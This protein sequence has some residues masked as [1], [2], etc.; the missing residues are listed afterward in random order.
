[1]STRRAWIPPRSN[2]TASSRSKPELSR[3]AAIK[4][5]VNVMVELTRL[6]AAGVPAAFT[7]GPRPDAK[8]STKTIANLG[9][10][11]LSLPDRSY[12][13]NTDAKSVE[14]RGRF[15]AHMANMFQLAG[16]TADAAAAKAKLVARFRNAAGAGFDRPCGDAR[17]E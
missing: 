10:G 3:I 7:F 17:S 6:H 2:A 14:T 8:D 4:G 11:G 9:Q 1:M 5:N 15:V 13:L 12:Y 16:D